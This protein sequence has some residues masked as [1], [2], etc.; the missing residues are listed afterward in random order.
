VL[1][2]VQVTIER[3]LKPSASGAGGKT[4]KRKALHRAA[5]EVANC[6]PPVGLGTQI[7]FGLLMARPR[8]GMSCD[9]YAAFRSGGGQQVKGVTAVVVD[10]EAV[11]AAQREGFSDEA[12]RADDTGYEVVA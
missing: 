8:R 3:A 6:A 2:Q 1:L 7:A 5:G 4:R 10:V 12:A 9:H 11:I